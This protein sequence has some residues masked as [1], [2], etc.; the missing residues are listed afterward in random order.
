MYL[1]RLIMNQKTKGKKWKKSKA[2]REEMQLFLDGYP[3]EYFCDYLEDSSG[4]SSG[5]HYGVKSQLPIS[6]SR[7]FI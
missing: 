3:D 2:A 4:E 1:L 5:V 6:L 7:S